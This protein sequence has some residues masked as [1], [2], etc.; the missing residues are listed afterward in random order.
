M[1][2][3]ALFFIRLWSG[4]VADRVSNNCLFPSSFFPKSRSLRGLSKVFLGLLGGLSGLVRP[5]LYWGLSPVH[6]WVPWVHSHPVFGLFRTSWDPSGGLWVFWVHSHPVRGPFRTSWDPSGGL[7]V[8]WVHSHPVR[9][10][11]R[12]SWDPPGDFWMPW[13]N[14]HSVYG[15]FRASWDQYVI[16]EGTFTQ[17]CSL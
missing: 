9:G 10:P 4:R 12:V 7:W 15:L 17:T 13:V 11:F 3:R 14:S 16:F 6:F 1:S 2:I 5:F 8:F